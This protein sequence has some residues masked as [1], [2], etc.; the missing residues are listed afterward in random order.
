MGNPRGGIKL[1]RS[2]KDQGYY[3]GQFARTARN[4][5]RRAARIARRK[6]EIPHPQ[7]GTTKGD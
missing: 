3:A 6:V 1:R 2:N 4:K 5:A 7:S